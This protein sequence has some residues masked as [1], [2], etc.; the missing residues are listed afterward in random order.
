MVHAAPRRQS[1]RSVGQDLTEAVLEAGPA[2]PRVRPLISTACGSVRSTQVPGGAVGRPSASQACIPPTTSVAR[3]RPRS[4]R[5]TTASCVEQPS[6]Q[7]RT[8]C[9]SGP[10]ASG[11]LHAP[12]GSSRHSST[13]RPTT[14]APAPHRRAGAGRPDGCRRGG[15]PP[16]G[17]PTPGPVT[18]ARS[19]PA[20]PA[21]TASSALARRSRH[22][23]PSMPTARSRRSMWCSSAATARVST[24]WVAADGV[25]RSSGGQV[26]AQDPAQ[27]LEGAGADR[28][29]AAAGAA[30]HA[31]LVEVEGH[32]RLGRAARHAAVQLGAAGPRRPAASSRTPPPAAG[33]R[34]VVSAR[35]APSSIW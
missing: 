15:R 17:P 11:I 28:H 1:G 35:S 32:E 27:E 34:P 23:W 7:S 18:G 24:S 22:T 31:A 3:S 12:S 30:Q 16:A 19:A 13:L 2:L 29:A 25:S 5:L 6:S 14:T 8:T 20:A 4:S 33:C 21:S 10:V 9:W 26:A